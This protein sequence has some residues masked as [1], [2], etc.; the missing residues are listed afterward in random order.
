LTSS[1]KDENPETTLLLAFLHFCHQ[2]FFYVARAAEKL[3]GQKL[4]AGTITVFIETDRFKPTAQY[5]T[6]GDA[7][8]Q[9]N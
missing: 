3:R 8:R 9:V 7:Q 5:S 4:A 1:I 2:L 6:F